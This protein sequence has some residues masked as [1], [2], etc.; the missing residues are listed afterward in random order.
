MGKNK[1]IGVSGKSGKREEAMRKEMENCLIQCEQGC[2]DS[3]I[4]VET[5]IKECRE[6]CR[7]EAIEHEMLMDDY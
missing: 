2:I 5:C 3:G 4:D 6:K 1:N 7:E